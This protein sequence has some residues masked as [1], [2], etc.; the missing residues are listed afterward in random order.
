MNTETIAY[1]TQI[2]KN[3]KMFNGL[4]RAASTAFDLPEGAMWILYFLIFSHEDITQQEVAER[5]L[6][7]KQTINSATAALAEKGLVTLEK[8]PGSKRKKITLTSEGKALTERT[9]KRLLNAECR[10]VERMG[11]EKIRAYISLYSEFFSCM[12]REFREEGI[13]N[14]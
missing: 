1:L 6:L 9:V 8:L 10:A 11:E 13:L 3:E 7:P 4:Y 14:A 5:M 2:S 12:E